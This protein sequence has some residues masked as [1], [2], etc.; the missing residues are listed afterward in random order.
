MAVKDV[1]TEIQELR[2]IL[3]GMI[4]CYDA[5]IGKTFDSVMRAMIKH[6]IKPSRDFKH[7]KEGFMESIS[8]M[9]EHKIELLKEDI[10]SGYLK[11]EWDED[12]E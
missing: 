8:L 5:P 3:A 4:E 6:N 1:T 7:E 12:D 11:C 10:R 2:S 9:I